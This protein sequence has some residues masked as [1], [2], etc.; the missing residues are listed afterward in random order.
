M[1]AKPQLNPFLKLALDLGPLIL[2]FFAN[3]HAGIFAATAVFMVAI[4][5]A[6]AISYAMTRQ[7][8]SCRWSPRSSW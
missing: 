5:A 1:T 4:V 3:S 6:L 7:L 2:F 8:R